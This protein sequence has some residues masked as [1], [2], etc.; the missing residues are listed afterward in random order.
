MSVADL[1]G[2]IFMKC[3]TRGQQLGFLSLAVGGV[4]AWRLGTG[5]IAS[6]KGY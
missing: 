5:D 2:A 4:N 1:R 6:P 3:E